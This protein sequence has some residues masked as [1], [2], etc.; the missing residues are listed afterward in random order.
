MVK[1]LL[2]ILLGGFVVFMLLA[3][4]DEWDYFSQ[5]WFGK[6]EGAP[7]VSDA[8]QKEAADTLHLGLSLMSHLYQSGGDPRFAERI[9]VA[10]WVLDE[11]QADIDYLARN[12]IL[13]D[14]ELERLDV[15]AVETL[16]SERLELETEE[17]WQ[18]RLR[19]AVDGRDLEPARIHRATGRYLLVKGAQGWRIDGWDPL[20]AEAATDEA[21]S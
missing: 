2:Q 11:I 1:R 16:T 3:I 10:E 21:S 8:E 7:A 6:A 20:P 5:A 13:Q 18:I 9:P 17:R 4:V 14:P 19:S 15:T 12:G